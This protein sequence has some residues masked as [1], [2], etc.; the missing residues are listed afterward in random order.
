MKEWV[1]PFCV[2]LEVILI[3]H[4][5]GPH[6]PTIHLSINNWS[7]ILPRRSD[8]TLAI[9][10]RN[11]GRTGFDHQLYSHRS[12][13]ASFRCFQDLFHVRPFLARRFNE[14]DGIVVLR[15]DMADTYMELLRLCLLEVSPPRL[16]LGLSKS[17][18]RMPLSSGSPIFIT[19][20]P[21]RFIA[22]C[23]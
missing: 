4:R 19:I 23:E 12:R 8:P 1:R 20:H 6:I 22:F 7:L 11:I 21:N 3:N 18:T 5:G 13:P 14:A 15:V 16:R 2:C 9:L 10:I 17:S